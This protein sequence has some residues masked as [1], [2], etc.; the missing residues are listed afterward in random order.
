MRFP[1]AN[2]QLRR[3]Q[4][5]LVLAT[6]VPSILMTGVGVI[7]LVLGAALMILVII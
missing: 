2:I 6:L 7:L 5:V 1:P 3:A 4:L